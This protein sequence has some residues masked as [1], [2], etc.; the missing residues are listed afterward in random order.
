[1]TMADRDGADEAIERL[2]GT[3]VD[4]QEIKVEEARAR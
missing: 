2:N 1:M 3:E 4:G